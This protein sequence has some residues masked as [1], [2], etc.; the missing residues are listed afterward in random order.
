VAREVLDRTCRIPN[1]RQCIYMCT[2]WMESR[3]WLRVD[4]DLGVFGE[5][6]QP[7]RR[8]AAE[9][10]LDEGSGLLKPTKMGLLGLGR[11]LYFFCHASSLLGYFVFCLYVTH[12]RSCLSIECI[13]IYNHSGKSLC[14][15]GQ[16]NGK[17]LFAWD[18]HGA[19]YKRWV[20]KSIGR[21]DEG[22]CPVP[23]TQSTVLGSTTAAIAIENGARKRNMPRRLTILR[24][25][26]RSWS[27]EMSGRRRTISW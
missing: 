15:C 17:R 24:P 25:W 11:N 21:D 14:S 6:K 27:A 10:H 12:V 2:T 13:Y 16:D 18:G 19:S 7:T 3:A 20:N 8:L 4:T 1:C 26:G 23:T 22:C 9:K 5:Q